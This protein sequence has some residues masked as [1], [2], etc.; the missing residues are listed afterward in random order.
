MRMGRLIMWNMVTLDGYFE[1]SKAWDISWH[2]VGWGEQLE[3]LSIEQT[4]AAEMLLFGRVTYAGMAAYWPSAKGEVADIMNA[5]P[6][7]VFS[8]T[9]ARADWNNTRLVRGAAEEEVPRLKQQAAK[10]LLIFGSATLTASLARRRLIDEYRLGLNPIALGAGNPLF[11]EGMKMK[12]LEARALKTG[13]VLLR[14]EAAAT[15]RDGE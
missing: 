5:I 14:Y 2:D 10:D 4:S 11:K 15:S 12:L 8:R 13:C 6:K 3:R 7:V 9:L 1:G